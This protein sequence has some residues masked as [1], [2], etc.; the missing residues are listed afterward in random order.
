MKNKEKRDFEAHKGETE[1]RV[2]EL[3]LKVDKVSV[4]YALLFYIK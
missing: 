3:N 1:K 4:W 2:S